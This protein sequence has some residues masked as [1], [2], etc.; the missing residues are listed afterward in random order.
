MGGYEVDFTRQNSN[1]SLIDPHASASNCACTH[2]AGASPDPVKPWSMDTTASTHVCAHSPMHACAWPWV[3]GLA[4]TWVGAGGY[5]LLGVLVWERKHVHTCT[6]VHAYTCTHTCVSM[7]VCVHVSACTWGACA[8]MCALTTV[9]VVPILGPT[10]S[11]TPCGC[12]QPKG[13]GGLLAHFI[14]GS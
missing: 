13:S 4:H 3:S 6:H 7:S 12:L 9:L 2:E 5:M 11:H 1:S 14:I 10:W 8:H